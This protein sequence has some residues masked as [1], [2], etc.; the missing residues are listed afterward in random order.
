MSAND[1]FL[2]GPATYTSYWR[3][4]MSRKLSPALK[5]VAVEPNRNSYPTDKTEK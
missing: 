4:A 3:P 1:T 2:V 5:A